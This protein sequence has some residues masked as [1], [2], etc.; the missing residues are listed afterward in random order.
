[1]KIVTASEMRDIDRVTAQRYGVPS[2]TLMENAGA[3]LAEF[4]REHYPHAS[5][6]AI[7]CGK[8]NN[9]GDGFVAA[10]KLHLAGKVVEV[11]L[12]AASDDLKGDAAEM[13][14]RLPVRSVEVNSEQQVR[15]EFE[16][17]FSHAD[18]FL[19][20]VLGTG[21]KPPV[22]SLYAAAIR[23]MNHSGL[24][25]VAVDVPSGADSDS[26]A[27][28]LGDDVV[29]A[30]T[31]VTFTAP[32]PVHV[33]SDLVRT[34][35]AVAPIGS[36]REAVTTHLGLNVITPP[37]FAK[38]LADRPLDSNKGIYGHALIVA[39]SFGK[40]GAAAMAGMSCLRSGA[41]LATVAT[42]KSVLAAVASYA[43]EIMTEP[44]AETPDGTLSRSALEKW[45]QLVKNMTVLAVGP[46]LSR[47]SE[48]VHVVREI[49][50]R[51]A[52]PTLLDADAL[53]ALAGQTEL[54]AQAKAPTIITPHPG[55]MARL[56]GTNVQSVQAD[57]VAVARQ[58]ASSRKTIVVLKGHKTVVASPSGE[59]WI[60]CTGNPGMA[61]GGTG[62]VLT[63]IIAGLLAQHP[64]EPLLCAI[65]GVFLHGLA[66]DVAR[67]HVGEISLMATDLIHV[68]PEAF[69]RA[70]KGLQKRWVTLN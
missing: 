11:L 50:R 6:I 9:G 22:S 70:K 17:S 58:F 57:R 67:D 68:L 30:D 40:S 13:F 33:F 21:F 48:T 64:K 60:N 19:D 8:G 35:T 1:M 52:I 18:L 2:L 7:I 37:D 62:D 32:K 54:L 23:A 28:Q 27:T 61:T 29:H 56:C 26:L 44:L 16:R 53:N 66:G 69:R 24:P 63:G 38:L 4:V 51:T 46:G 47:N 39:G 5:R 65:A 3:A 12:L 10:R 31:A 42:P 34:T 36:P 49:L 43:A 25:V 14:D 15:H 59:T 20:A 41:G 55:E 45:D